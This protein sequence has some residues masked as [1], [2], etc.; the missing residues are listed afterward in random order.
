MIAGT[1]SIRWP[2]YLCCGRSV[3]HSLPGGHQY[4]KSCEAPSQ[5]KPWERLQSSGTDR[6][7]KL[8]HG[9]MGYEGSA[10]VRFVPERTSGK[11]YHAEYN[12]IT[13]ENDPER[14][15]TRLNS[16]H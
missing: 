14:K 3:L 9:R 8:H 16:S 5:R 10:P 1:I 15:S 6:R 11:K 2:G 4:R 12:S 13:E 7:Q